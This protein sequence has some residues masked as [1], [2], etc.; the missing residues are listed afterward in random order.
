M[1]LYRE[2]GWSGRFVVLICAESLK[3]SNRLQVT[4]PYHPFPFSFCEVYGNIFFMEFTFTITL[5]SLGVSKSDCGGL[6]RTFVFSYC[7]SLKWFWSQKVLHHL[8][9]SFP[10]SSQYYYQGLLYCHFVSSNI[11]KML[12][13]F[14]SVTLW[15]SLIHVLYEAALTWHDHLPTIL[16]LTYLFLFFSIFFWL[17]PVR[18]S[19]ALDQITFII[20]E[21]LCVSST[22]PLLANPFHPL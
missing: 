15:L 10:I 11:C 8:S 1:R 7:V 20:S 18:S 2:G 6:W 14:Y 16:V 9:C 12:N 4:L 13:N 3:R 21:F 17:T 5:R 22:V 19:T